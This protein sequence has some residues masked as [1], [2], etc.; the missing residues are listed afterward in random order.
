MQTKLTNA[1]DTT[2][3]AYSS[4]KSVANVT[5]LKN[6]DVKVTSAKVRLTYIMIDVYD[7]KNE[8]L[9]HASVQITV[10]NGVKLN[11][12]SARQYGRF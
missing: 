4:T 11:G 5:I 3:K 2:I 12:N 7:K 6:G 10:Q 9:T 1:A 8:F